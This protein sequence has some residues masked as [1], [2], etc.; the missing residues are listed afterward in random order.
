M[1]SSRKRGPGD[2]SRRVK[3]YFAIST[4]SFR[5]SITQKI[6]ENYAPRLGAPR[7]KYLKRGVIVQYYFYIRRYFIKYEFY[8]YPCP[9]PPRDALITY[10]P[11]KYERRTFEIHT[12]GLRRSRTFEQRKVTRDVLISDISQLDDP[13]FLLLWQAEK[14]IGRFPVIALTVGCCILY[15][16]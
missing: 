11:R 8:R 13:V 10:Q 4:E 12:N 1:R 6:Y 14:L 3:I 15:S 7:V 2:Y 5:E 16:T 9:G